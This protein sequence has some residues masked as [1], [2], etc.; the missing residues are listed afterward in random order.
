MIDVTYG[1]GE[2]GSTLP[3]GGAGFDG[4]TPSFVSCDAIRENMFRLGFTS[5]IEFTRLEN[6]RDG[7]VVSKYIVAPIAGTTGMDALPCQPVFVAEVLLASAA[8]VGTSFGKYIDIVTDRPMSPYPARYAVSVS[9]LYIVDSSI[10]ISGTLATFAAY[11][12]LCPPLLDTVI[13]SRDVASPQT[14]QSFSDPL[15][16]ADALILGS[17]AVDD[18]GDYAYDEGI[19]NLKKRVFRRLI[20]KPGSFPHMPDYGVGISTYAKT[21]GTAAVRSNLAAL[22]ETQISLEPD[23]AKVVVRVVNDP[24]VPSLVRFRVLVQT[25]SGQQTKFE[26]PFSAV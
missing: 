24:S 4:D 14:L 8:D 11:K 13:P 17:F 5:T 19:V 22:A 20:F 6:V 21:I 16:R 12:Q 9:R 2:Y 1:S 10:E 15:P 3:W 26:V 23:V 7:S 25:K 18:N